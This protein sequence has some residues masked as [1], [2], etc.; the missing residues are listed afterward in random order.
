MEL[1]KSLADSRARYERKL[2]EQRAVI[3]QLGARW[4]TFGYLRGVLFLAAIFCLFLA[5]NQTFGLG[6]GW[7]WIAGGI[8]VVFC[9]VAI[10]H[11]KMSVLMRTASLL[12]NMHD[13]SL[14]RLARDWKKI[15]T[16]DVE[17]DPQFKAT[18]FDLDLVGESS[19]FKLIGITRTPLGTNILLDWISAGAAPQVILKRQAA[20][21][22]L[23]PELEWREKF[24][25]NC[26]HLAVGQSGPSQFIE[27]SESESWLKTNAWVLWV[28]R[29][30]SIV[31]IGAII[32][33]IFQICTLSIA[34]IVMCVAA[35]VN[36]MLSVVFAGGLHDIFNL[37]SSRRNEITYYVSQFDMVA[38]FDAKSELLRELQNSMLVENNDARQQINR[39]GLLVWLAN[40]RRHG[41]FFIIY[42]ALEI[43]FFWDVHVLDLLEKW[44]A[45]NHG[46]ARL[47][48]TELG[49][50]EALC[51]LA[52]LKAD[53]PDWNFPIVQLPVAK[54][55]AL[56][57]CKQ[58]GH[59]L[60][61]DQRVCNDVNV[62]PPGT[63]LLVSGSNMSG[64]ST[65]M[66]SVGVNAVLAQMGSVVCADKMKLPPVQIETSMRIVDS[67]ADGI[68]FF[69]A[70]LKRLKEIVDTAGDFA[71][72]TDKSL[73]FLLDEILQGTN[74][75]E[76]QIAVSRVVRKLIDEHAIGAIST[77]D[78]DLAR[79]DDLKD[80]CH[81]VHFSEQFIEVDGKRKMTF[82][83]Q[84]K[85]GI[86]ETTNALKLL[87][88]VGLGEDD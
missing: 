71:K 72:K 69:M 52:K 86:A 75:R 36:F 61:D 39:L 67:L 24:R 3:E 28:A 38:D 40:L 84:M 10:Y 79:T 9:G 31:F 8:F 13:Q 42:L 1:P 30:A 6:R 49:Q 68:S 82:D 11:E 34:F 83:Y 7:V 20:I 81:S 15:P 64:K 48:F 51:A 58:L 17:L 43:C 66:R 18:A 21:A 59:P 23:A 32:A 88:M 26:E 19:L 5:L 80:A 78:L 29:V 53:H 85:Q 70:E 54:D 76:R 46:K 57:E 65:L 60:L 44:K 63:V 55:Q 33:A 27:W 14:A 22:E 45:E 50:W 4:N 41:F 74:S 16:R 25:L 2:A 87:E 47:W 12:A 62:G 37:I 35:A 77:H 73:L 56:I